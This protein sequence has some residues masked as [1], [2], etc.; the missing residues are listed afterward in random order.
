MNEKQENDLYDA[1]VLLF[2]VIMI[3]LF[4]LALTAPAQ[5]VGWLS[6][7]LW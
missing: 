6:W 5:S 3:I 7:K 1:L 4:A 2:G